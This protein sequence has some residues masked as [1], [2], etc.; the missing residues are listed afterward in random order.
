[1]IGG[2]VIDQAV[3]ARR[4]ADNQ[5]IKGRG[6]TALSSG[7]QFGIIVLRGLQLGGHVCHRFLAG[8]V[9]PGKSFLGKVDFFRLKEFLDKKI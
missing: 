6:I 4:V 3:K 7:N 9:P 1:M 5:L 2:H 8:A